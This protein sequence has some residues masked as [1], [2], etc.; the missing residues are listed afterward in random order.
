MT[1]NGMRVWGLVYTVQLTLN[2]GGFAEATLINC[3][4]NLK[5]A[6]QNGYTHVRIWK[7]RFLNGPDL[8][9]DCVIYTKKNI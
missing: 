7:G 2:V 5:Q 3:S 4:N 9:L 6:D 8:D 1:V